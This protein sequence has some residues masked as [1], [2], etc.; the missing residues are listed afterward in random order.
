MA[1][2]FSASLLLLAC[3]VGVAQPVFA[4]ASRSDGWSGW[5]GMQDC[6]TMSGA[7]SAS[8]LLTPQSHQALEAAPSSP[9]FRVL[10]AELKPVPACRMP[11]PRPAADSQ[12]DQSLTYLRTARLRL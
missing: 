6:R 12:T 2:W 8:I 3:L 11:A 7:P 4:G 5:F 9:A 1:R 10:A